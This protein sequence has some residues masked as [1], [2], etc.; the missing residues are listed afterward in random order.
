M[1]RSSPV[2]DELHPDV[3]PLAFLLGS[4]H[5]RGT[6]EYP[7]VEP[8][9]YEEQLEFAH[10]GKPYLTYRQRTWRLLD[11]DRLP[12]HM[13]LAFWR[14]GPNGGVE[15]ISAHP[16]GVVEIEIGTVTAGR[17]SWP[18]RRWRPPPLRRT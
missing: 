16:N 4:W 3:T 13:E 2:D 9:E 10:V 8:F 12:S 7:T 14:P 15:V 5:G 17:V 1:V 11:G 6:G 18:P